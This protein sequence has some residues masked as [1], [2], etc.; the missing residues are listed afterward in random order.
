MFSNQFFHNF[1]LFALRLR[2]G[3]KLCKVM[4]LPEV[5][6]HFLPVVLQLTVNSFLNSGPSEDHK[7]E[8]SKLK[9]WSVLL[10]CVLGQET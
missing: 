1:Y 8:W 2:N 5:C 4:R 9:H 3:V 7:I 10:H 6:W